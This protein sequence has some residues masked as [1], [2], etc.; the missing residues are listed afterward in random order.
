MHESPERYE[1][2]RLSS[3]CSQLLCEWLRWTD[4]VRQTEKNTPS[5]TRKVTQMKEARNKLNAANSKRSRH[6]REHGCW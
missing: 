6:I 3:E 2:D 5:Y 1:R 4:E